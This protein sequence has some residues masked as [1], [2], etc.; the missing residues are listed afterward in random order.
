MDWLVNTFLGKKLRIFCRCCY[1]LSKNK[2]I[3]GSMLA[4]INTVVKRLKSETS[5]FDVFSIQIRLQKKKRTI[6][7]KCGPRRKKTCLWWFT[8]NKGTDQPAHPRKLISAF[9]V[10]VLESIISD[11]ATSEFSSFQLVSVAGETGLSLALSDT[12]KKGFVASSSNS[13]V[14]F[15]SCAHV[16][17]VEC[18]PFKRFLPTRK[19][20]LF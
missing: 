17:L 10:R 11:L 16:A 18:T 15:K 2:I 12:P 7:Q 3:D 13:S 6:S 20:P 19:L 9:V 5:S 4:P 14:C 1:V 8:S